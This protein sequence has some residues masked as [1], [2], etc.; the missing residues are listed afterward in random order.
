MQFEDVSECVNDVWWID[1]K[2]FL[3]DGIGVPE[4][5]QRDSV[6][7]RIQVNDAYLLF[8]THFFKILDEIQENGNINLFEPA[9]NI[10]Y[11]WQFSRWS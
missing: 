6:K 4:F 3:D 9:S 5:R 11:A 10:Y 8:A 1:Q 7:K 2:L